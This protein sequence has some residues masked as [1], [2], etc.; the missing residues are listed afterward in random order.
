MVGGAPGPVECPVK[1]SREPAD[2]R[3]LWIGDRPVK[4]SVTARCV[5]GSLALIGLIAASGHAADRT[6]TQSGPA[7]GA[8]GAPLLRVVGA[9]GTPQLIRADGSRVR[10]ALGVSPPIGS[11]VETDESSHVAIVIAP[12]TGAAAEQADVLLLGPQTRVRFAAA[13]LDGDEAPGK[14]VIEAVVERGTY[15]AL[16]RQAEADSAYV[17]RIGARRVLLRG[18]DL[19]GTFNPEK[20]DAG[21]LLDKGRLTIE[22]GERKIRLK[23][24]MMR[25][26]EGGRVLG[27]RALA[28]SRWDE[29]IAQTAVPGVDMTQVKAAVVKP[30]AES[31]TAATPGQKPAAEGPTDRE[32][33]AIRQSDGQETARQGPRGDDPTRISATNQRPGATRREIVEEYIYVRMQTTKGD[34]ILELDRGRAPITVDNFLTYVETGFYQGTLFHRVMSTFAIQAG[35]YT[36]DWEKKKT[37]PPIKCEWPNGLSNRRGTIAMERQGR[38]DSATSHFFIN[39]TNNPVLDNP[40]GRSGYAVFGK[41]IA[42]MDVVDAIKDTPVQWSRVNERERAEPVEPIVIEEVEVIPPEAAEAARQAVEK[43]GDAVDE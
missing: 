8:A 23:G 18:A 31:A 33:P 43:A 5:F 12:T 26:I 36:T 19:I 17:L 40:P 2:V 34:I 38:P 16:V 13:G 11:A 37:G 41:V 39:V 21:F 42:G 4:M 25:T 32:K 35:V 20:D 27:A 14:P 30:G 9:V 7:A 22:A 6:L 10:L 15:R 1:R 28:Q 3:F 24:G 29:A